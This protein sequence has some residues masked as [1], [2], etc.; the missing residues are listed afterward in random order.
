MSKA[1]TVIIV[2][3]ILIIAAIGFKKFNTSESKTTKIGF[4]DIKAGFN[5]EV[6]EWS[7][8]GLKAEC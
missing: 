7:I 5:F 8:V 4:E 1:L 6:I 3:A 2:I